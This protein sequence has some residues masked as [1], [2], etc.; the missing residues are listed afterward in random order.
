MLSCRHR[1]GTVVFFLVGMLLCTGSLSS[2]AI[3]GTPFNDN[4]E[5]YVNGT[6]LNGNNGWSG[7]VSAVVTNA[8]ANTGTNSA[9]IPSDVSLTNETSCGNSSNVWVDFSFWAQFLSYAPPTPSAGS[10]AQFFFNENG[11]PVVLD[12]VRTNWSTNAVTLA[13]TVVP[14]ITTGAWVRATVFLNFN[15]QKWALFVNNQLIRDD[16]AFHTADNQFNR[17]EVKNETYLDNFWVNTGQPDGGTTSNSLATLTSDVDEDGMPDA[18]ELSYF[19]EV[20]AILG[21]GDPDD[22][23]RSNAEEYFLGSN[24][25]VANQTPQTLP[26]REGFESSPTGVVSASSWHGATNSGLVM[27]QNSHYIEGGQGIYLSNGL[28]NITF[29]SGDAT[30]VWVQIYSK[31]VFASSDASPSVASNEVGAYYVASSGVLRAYSGS[32]W[33]NLNAVIPGN[34]WIGFATHLDY[35]AKKWDL[36]VS[37]NGVYGD[38][39]V[40]A[41]K[42]GAMD[43]NT[44]ATSSATCLTNFIIELAA[45]T[46]M[47]LDVVAASYGYTNL[48][49]T[50]S[51][52][53][54][55]DRIVGQSVAAA[56]PPYNY[57]SINSV[58]NTLDGQLGIDL[59]RGL[60]SNDVVYVSYTNG[61]N[62]YALD[63]AMLWQGEGAIVASN[64]YIN[65]SM[66]MQMKKVSGRDTVVFYPFGE[67]GPASTNVILVEGVNNPTVE[68]WNFLAS[69]FSTV[70]TPNH[71]TLNFGFNNDAA[72]GDRIYLRNRMLVFSTWD[73]KWRDG[74]KVATN[75]LAPGEA[76]WYYR[77]AATSFT[78]QISE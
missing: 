35:D 47:Y 24:P 64:L 14:P 42:Y 13:N 5:S 73:S 37:T 58:T 56:M 39:M 17:F 48:V 53:V 60:T 44:A 28:I 32:A 25:L 4:F 34:K 8:R 68:G 74:A 7:D 66:G 19:G 22:D 21:S 40:R 69:P 52:V 11:Y 46:N 27:V 76:F 26:Y 77:K 20:A 12:G 30:N 43:F 3:N 2:A 16:I 65:K 57:G 36:Y 67:Y 70:R 51:N 15:L 50:Y 45:E 63:A 49:T 29:A 59:K 33:S 10:I 31:P 75:Q 18:W 38:V 9:Y 41:N 6:P 72:D 62:K 61:L 55:Y 54:A 78:W 1:L 23:G 71:A